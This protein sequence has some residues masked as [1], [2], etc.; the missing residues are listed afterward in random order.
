MIGEAFAGIAFLRNV[1]SIA[2]IFAI[3]P[4][5]NS[6]GLTQM[7]VVDGIWCYVIAA[8]YIPFL[9][10]GKKFRRR[11]AARYRKFSTRK[12]ERRL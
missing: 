2:L 6:Q 4:W 11:T 12:G 3:V 9:I 10:W 7:F 8:L 1:F 5:M